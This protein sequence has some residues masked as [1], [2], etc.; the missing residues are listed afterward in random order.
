MVSGST[1]QSILGVQQRSGT[2][3]L[4]CRK[5]AGSQSSAPW[6]RATSVLRQLR[7]LVRRAMI[8]GV[9]FPSAGETA[10]WTS[11]SAEAQVYVHG[12]RAQVLLEQPILATIERTLNPPVFSG[13]ACVGFENVVP[14]AQGGLDRTARD[15]RGDSV[16]ADD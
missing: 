10:S 15:S 2:L 13:S 6:H 3:L 12:V 14:Q 8:S 1:S 5:T 11:Q 9:C 7:A 4:L 16:R